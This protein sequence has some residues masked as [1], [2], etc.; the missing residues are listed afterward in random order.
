MNQKEPTETFMMI[1]NLNKIFGFDL[2]YKNLWFWSFF[3]KLIYNFFLLHKFQL[4]QTVFIV[5]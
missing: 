4:L 2:F 3:Y 1:L 5:K